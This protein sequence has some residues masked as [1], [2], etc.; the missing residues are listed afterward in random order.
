MES[1]KEG[2]SAHLAFL[3]TNH[4][5]C[6][7]TI[8]VR[9]QTFPIHLAIMAGILPVFQKALC[10]NFKEG[11]DK[12]IDLRDPSIQV[13]EI[14]LD[15]VYGIC[16]SEQLCNFDLCIK[17]LRDSELYGIQGLRRATCSFAMEKFSPGRLVEMMRHVDVYGTEEERAVVQM[18]LA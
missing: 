10:G 3:R 9:G 6:D 7:A 18:S 4:D 5:K 11:T 8:V 17:V 14:V 2:A 15:F 1:V 12:S 13:V 16:T